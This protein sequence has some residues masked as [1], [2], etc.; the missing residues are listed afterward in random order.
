MS[1]GD[2]W[3]GGMRRR[4]PFMALLTASTIS[5]TGTAMSALAIPWLVL[6]T[7]GSA[8]AT[9]LVAFAQMAPYVAAQALTG[10]LVDRVG[11]RRC[12]VWGN[13]VAAAAVAAIPIVHAAGALTQPVLVVLVA[14]A[15]T[16]RGAA[17]C[18]SVALVPATA[19]A[20][21][22]TMERAAGVNAA[23]PLTAM[24]VGASLAG[25]LVAVSGPLT[26]L[27][28]DAATFAIAATI[29]AMWVRV[30]EPMSAVPN[31]APVPG[32]DRGHVHGYLRDLAAGLRFLR[33]DRLLLGI[34]T[35]VAVTNLLNHARTEVMLPVWVRTEI[36]SA[37]ALG[38]I[39]S[40]G[41]A[42]SLL[43]IVL[44]TWLGPRVSRRGLYTAGF[45]LGGGP[46]FITLALTGNLTPVL[47][48]VLI[49]GAFGGSLNMVIGATSYERI[50][51]HLRARVLGTFRASAWIGIPFG[52]LAGGFATEAL[53][54]RPALLIFGG[55]YLLTS[56]T[57]LVFPAWRQM[58]RPEPATD[59]TPNRQPAHTS[60]AS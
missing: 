3:R 33:Q 17:D 26:V 50:P 23:T 12:F 59:P 11:M 43:G 40:T 20:G 4:T 54:L 27:A 8:A 35:M 13:L 5:L 34:V 2:R 36:G 21:G 9:G 15:G 19:E 53:G 46:V 55:I 22:V 38:L 31:G 6:T 41:G 47:V 32:H 48:V 44:G 60:T 58:R 57:P 25:V 51:E 49:G 14:G 42:A 18:A 52:A 45:L 10:P 30:P 39:S 29:V 7:T 16:V 56:L 28:V 1:R 37:T 24:L